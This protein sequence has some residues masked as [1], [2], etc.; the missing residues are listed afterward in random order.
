MCGTRLRRLVC[1]FLLAS[2]LFS[3]SLC[4]DVILSE[5]DYQEL[6]TLL[7]NSETEITALEKDLDRARNSLDKQA[8]ILNQLM[9]MRLQQSKQLD[10]LEKS[11]YELKINE[12]KSKFKT[13][14][15]CIAIGIVFGISLSLYANYI[16]K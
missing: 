15:W 6:L 3:S 7:D 13:G 2:L 12:Y 5:E 4:A 16:K 8:G 10:E 14:A 1:I 9:D 11:C